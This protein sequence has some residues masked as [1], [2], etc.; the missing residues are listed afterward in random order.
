MS[1]RPADRV[2]KNEELA[3][4]GGYPVR[5]T[6]LPYGHQTIDDED[7]A[8]VV[9]VL[10]GDWITQ[11]P[12]IEEFENAVANY[13]GAKHGVAFSSG[14]AALH[15]ACA[16]AGLGPGDE[17][18]TTPLTFV[19]TANAVV[20]C[21][22]KPVFADIEADTLNI[23]AA[24]IARRITP[25]TK[26][27]LPVDFTGHPADL[28]EILKLANQH[29]LAVIEDACHALG[30][31]CRGRRVGSISHMTVF[32]FHPVKHIT[33]GEGGMVTTDN[34]E[35]ARKLRMFRNH[36]IDSNSRQRQVEG[37][38]HYEVE[39]LGYNYRLTDISCA[40]GLSQLRNLDI[41]LVR[42]R[43]IAARYTTAFREMPALTLPTVRPD[44]VP[45]WHLYLIR[46]RSEQLAADREE[47]FSALRGERIG[48]NVHYIPV[49]LHPFY[50]R[51][52][53][54][55]PGLYPVAEAAYEQILSLPI[56]P[57]MSDADVEDVIAAVR[58]VVE[59]F[60]R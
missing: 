33:T 53:G 16:A 56:F 49:H 5:Q 29:G 25:R 20:Y 39:V 55:G 23:N 36:G 18:I 38:W 40:L 27:I 12:K 22:A 3:I 41:Y 34:A 51:R 44:V 47:I 19:A 43:R 31:V 10:R 8:A 1:N 45:A 2:L 54:T 15:A 13:C 11:G 9:E 50:R 42:R 37:Q 7:I 14:T 46:L 21:G 30:A 52:F 35:L 57:G 59:A 24:E 28:D 4:H 58:K 17:A 48:V 6:W 60:L 32:S 26:A